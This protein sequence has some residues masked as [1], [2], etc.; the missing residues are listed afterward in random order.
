[1]KPV[2]HPSNTRV[3]GAPVGWDH[4][5]LPRDGLGIT[6]ARFGEMR[7]VKSYWRP[8][9]AELAVLNAGGHVTLWIPG[10]TMPPAAI[11][12]EV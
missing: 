10:A 11:E 12:V 3:L 8:S 5:K 6:D 7:A 9:A 4:D 2:K 1:M